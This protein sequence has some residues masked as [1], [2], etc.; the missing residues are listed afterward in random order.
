MSQ[1]SGTSARPCRKE[2]AAEKGEEK[3]EK[4]GKGGKGRRLMQAPGPAAAPS[5]G[6]APGPATAPAPDDPPAWTGG[7][8][9]LA[10]PGLFVPY[11][12]SE[13]K[14]YMEVD[15]HLP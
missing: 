3:G 11:L 8:V 12:V 2:T 1:Q 14:G 6:P 15:D 4:G 7:T 10:W 9:S 13:P 5:P